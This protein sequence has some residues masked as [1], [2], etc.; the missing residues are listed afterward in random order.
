MTT[1]DVI[2][3]SRMPGAEQVTPEVRLRRLN[4]RRTLLL[5]LGFCSALAAAGYAFFE[6]LQPGTTVST[7]DAYVAATLAEVTPQIDGIISRIHVYDTQHVRRGDVLVTLDSADAD[8]DVEAAQAAYEQ[9]YRRVQQ[10]LANVS[11]A[12]SNV[13]AKQSTVIQAKLQLQRRKSIEKS[14]AIAGEEISNA[15]SVLDAAKYDVAIAK[16]Q[17]A[18]R[19]ATVQDINIQSNPE[20]LAAKAVLDRAK[21]RLHRTE[22]RAPV[23]G[24]IA[25]SRAQIG[26]QISAGTSLMSIVPIKQLYVEANFKES[27][28]ERIRQGQPVTLTSDLYGSDHLFHGYVEGL[29]GGTGSAFAVIPP[30]NAT[31]NWIK[32]V[33]RL[34][35]RIA[36][37]PSELINATLR[38]GLSMTATIK[39]DQNDPF[40]RA[41][42]NNLLPALRTAAAGAY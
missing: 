24:I 3:G 17:L 18:A 42:Q 20:I 1:A 14:G 28:L 23:D 10:D 8:L 9:A 36:L 11:A 37:D 35:I 7:D 16:H 22:I 41:T 21:L 19:H 26:Q 13:A 32:V 31:G 25:Q 4:L 12:E 33:Q 39:L 29:G 15:R 27:Q 40:P 34:P 5:T 38:V 6:I 2:S 30:Q